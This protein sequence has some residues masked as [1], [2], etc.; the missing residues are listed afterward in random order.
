MGLNIANIKFARVTRTTAT[1][2]IAV[3]GT[4]QVIP[5]EAAIGAGGNIFGMWSSSVNPSRIT[6]Q[7]AGYYHCVANVTFAAS[8]TGDRELYF[9]KNGAGVIG[10]QSAKSATLVTSQSTAAI[11]ELVAGDYLEVFVN[12]TSG[13]ALNITTTAANQDP[14]FTVCLCR[15]DADFASVEVGGM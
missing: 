10:R 1:L 3:S 12:Q 13:G 8:A 7:R 15:P 11:L 5:F 6:I 9:V 14:S 2:S 4:P